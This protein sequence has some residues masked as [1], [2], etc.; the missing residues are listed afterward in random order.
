MAVPEDKIIRKLGNEVALYGVIGRAIF[1]G[2]PIELV[3]LNVSRSKGHDYASWPA[4]HC[5]RGCT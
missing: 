2:W 1:A 4:Q 5:G 3:W